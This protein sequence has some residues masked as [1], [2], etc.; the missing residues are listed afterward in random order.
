MPYVIHKEKDTIYTIFPPYI[1]EVLD[2]DFDYPAYIQKEINQ[3]YDKEFLEDWF[4]FAPEK[5]IRQVDSE[6]T[7]LLDDYENAIIPLQKAYEADLETGTFSM[8][9]NAEMKKVAQEYQEKLE[10]MQ[11]LRLQKENEF[12]ALTAKRTELV[13]ALNQML[14]VKRNI[15][16]NSD[17]RLND[18]VQRKIPL[19][20]LYIYDLTH[21]QRGKSYSKHLRKLYEYKR[22]VFASMLNDEGAYYK[23]IKD[24]NFQRKQK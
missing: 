5:P 14:E 4:D 3:T 23:P 11:K 15:E 20:N 6:L 22:H 17:K 21:M 2:E 24:L 19:G 16:Q 1:E 10:N 12:K 18:F 8:D 13:S 7:E 9:Y